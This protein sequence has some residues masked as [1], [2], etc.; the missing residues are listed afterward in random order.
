MA[1]CF[2]FWRL[3]GKRLLV[4]WLLL[5][6]AMTALNIFTGC[7]LPAP[8]VWYMADGRVSYIYQAKPGILIWAAAEIIF[9]IYIT[10][11]AH[12]KIGIN[13]GDRRRLAPL[14]LGTICLF[15]EAVYVSHS[16]E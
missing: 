14:L 15:G 6:V 16:G 4:F 8:T 12:K 3:P 2:A 1:F 5:S 10:I 11:L 13:Y 9:L 7:L